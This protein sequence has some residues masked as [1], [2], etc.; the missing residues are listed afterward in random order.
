MIDQSKGTAEPAKT[1]SEE[2]SESD[3]IAMMTGEGQEQAEEETEESAEETTDDTE[4]DEGATE[5]DADEVEVEATGEDTE[6]ETEGIDLDSLTDEQWEAVRTKLKSRA[7]AD[8]QRLKREA[9]AKDEQINA[10]RNQQP[11]N[12]TLAPE[13]VESRFLVGIESAEQLAEKVASLKKLA[14]D[15]DRLLDEHEDFGP[16][17]LIDVGS[18]SYTKKQLRQLSREIRETLDE[19]VPYQQ[20]KFQRATLIEKDL[21]G[22][23]E[24]L[25]AEVKDLEDDN[26]EVAKTFKGLTESELFQSIFKSN[27]EAKPV[28]TLLAGF[29]A[30]AIL[31][32]AVAKSAPLP[33]ATGKIPKANPPSTP[34]G[35]AA[36]G[37]AR[38]LPAKDKAKANYERR[39]QE[40]GSA[41]DLVKAM[42]L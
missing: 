34:S 31:G 24:R 22:V 33:A 16:N 5:E 21:A 8:I 40:T 13:P 37:P 4:T 7:A 2:L 36:A 26:S 27:P 30:K 20:S 18:Q 3:L 9:K 38:G 12:S 35:A 32:K 6:G 1:A 15:T 25:K 10:L 17:D 11:Q 41:D 19:A 14:K 28:L 42:S 39:F 29:G 23:K